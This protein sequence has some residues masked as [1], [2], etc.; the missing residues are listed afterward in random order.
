MEDLNEKQILWLYKS[1]YNFTAI[2]GEDSYSDT[3][4]SLFDREANSHFNRSLVNPVKK[5]LKTLEQ[6]KASILNKEEIPI[7]WSAMKPNMD[8]TWLYVEIKGGIEQEK[9]KIQLDCLNEKQIQAL[10][11]AG[12][13]FSL[14]EDVSGIK[15]NSIFNGENC[16]STIIRI[17]LV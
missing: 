1:G 13:E 14:Y 6:F 2:Y 7:I 8:L 17:K 9:L 12:Y 10:T 3:H 16:P 5:T 11:D 4:I 15:T